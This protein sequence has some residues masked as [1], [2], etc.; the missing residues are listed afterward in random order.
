VNGGKRS[1]HVFRKKDGELFW[2]ML[3][4]APVIHRKKLLY[5][6]ISWLDITDRKRAEEEKVEMERKAHLASRLA[7]VG[8]MASGIAHEINNPLT[9]VIGFAQLLMDTDL[10]EDIKEDLVIIHKEAQRA[11]GVARNLLTFARKHAPSK[12]PTNI[13]SII[14]GVLSLRAYEQNVSNIQIITKL[15]SDLPEVMADYSQLQQVFINIILNA[16]GAMLEANNGG[17]L[18]ITTQRVNNSIRASLADNGP[19]I[20]QDNIDRIFDPFFTTKEVGKGTGLG[21]SICHGI[22][23]EHGGKIYV[24]SKPG[25]GATF[26]VELPVSSQ[27]EQS[28]ELNGTV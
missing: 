10:P 21:L 5:F 23:A 8:E 24:K 27:L 25:S 17:T 16:E 9:A 15:A 7:S 2:V 1:E 14:E 11:A 13:N 26:I 4:S 20:S 6:L 22:I 12:Q 28:E 18:T 3:N 19:G